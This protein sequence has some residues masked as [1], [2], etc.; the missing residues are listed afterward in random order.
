MSKHAAEPWEYNA[1]EGMVRNIRGVVAM[2]SGSSVHPAM[3]AIDVINASGL[4]CAAA[5]ELLVLAKSVRLHFDET[6]PLGKLARKAIAKAGQ[7]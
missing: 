5:P 2:M 3:N 4:L 6:H 1:D 7:E